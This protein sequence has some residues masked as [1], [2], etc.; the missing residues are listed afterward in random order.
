MPRD[1]HSL[2]L[3]PHAPVEYEGFNLKDG[4]LELGLPGALLAAPWRTQT[5]SACYTRIRMQLQRPPIPLH[6]NSFLLGAT[7]C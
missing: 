2:E 4:L 6:Q 7:A 5:G 1:Q 3:A